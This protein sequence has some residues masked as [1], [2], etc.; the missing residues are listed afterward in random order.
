MRLNETHVFAVPKWAICLHLQDV[1]VD[2]VISF[3]DPLAL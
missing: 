2:V 3:G 1:D